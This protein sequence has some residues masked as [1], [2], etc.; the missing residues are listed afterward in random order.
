M[1]SI[2]RSRRFQGVIFVLLFVAF[3]GAFL[4][5]DA[6][7]LIGSAP[8]TTGTAVANVNGQEVTYGSWMNAAQNLQNERE[9]EL[10][11]SLTMDERQRIEQ[12]AF[13]ELVTDILLTEEY[14]RRNITVSDAEVQ[15][16]ALYSPHPQLLQMPELQTEGR[17]DLQKYQRYM[18]SPAVRQGGMLAQ[19][20][21]YYRAEL[22]KRK[23]FDQVASDVYVT[24]ARLW[25]MWQDGHDSAQVSYAALRPEVVADS[26]VQVTD[27]EIR[28]WYDRRRRDLDRP[29]RAVVSVVAIPRTVTAADSAATRARLLMLRNEIVSGGSFDDVA[30]RESVDSM[31]AANGGALPR[32][33][34]GRFVA[35]FENA[36]YAL[37][38]GEVSQPVLTP[39]GYHLIKVDERKGDTLALRH[40]LVRI[41]QSD[42]S[43]TRTDRQ[44]DELGRLAAGS[45]DPA[46]FDSAAKRMSLPVVS[47]QVVEGEPANIAGVQVPDVS[48]WAFG[49]A[50]RGETSDLFS[51]D[52]AYYLARLD[53]LEVGGIPKIDDIREL[54]RREIIREKKLDVLMPRARKIASAAA[55][56]TLESAAQAE[57]VQVMQ[58]PMFTRVS[59]LPGLGAN[60]P[61]FGAAFTL[62]VGS[63]SAPIRA[64]NGVFVIR[65]ER[66]VNA[67]RAAW[68]A[69]REQQREQIVQALRQRRVAEYVDNLRRAATIEDERREVTARGRALEEES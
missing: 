63:V 49:G 28:D 60:T 15:E 8:V 14:E 65:V 46:K 58:S 30:R 53:T 38:A 44:A 3:V 5:A 56:S 17:F 47:G 21:G 16:T 27:A 2:M 59:Q 36:A 66:R 54:I 12:E 26:A 42:S 34:R 39:Y 22:R 40:I 29:G 67:D 18:S 33:V 7:G 19:L 43:A 20:E 48:A 6:S 45:D 68:E 69:Q 62:P 24:D 10:G 37:R 55:A 13:D 31:S 25:S 61:V 64:A 50:R 41:G 9:A 32:G 52:R 4:F 23:L 1:L 11:R 57:G 51:D 35:E